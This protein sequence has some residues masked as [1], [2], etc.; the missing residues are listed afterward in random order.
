LVF[1]DHDD[2]MLPHCIESL[3]RSFHLWPDV[4]AAHSDHQLL[5]VRDGSLIR[6]HHDQS[7][8]FQ[9]MKSIPTLA[10]QGNTRLYG[11]E[12]YT[13]LL[14]GNLLQQ[15]WIVDRTALQSVGGYDEKIRYCEDWDLYL[16]ITRRFQVVLSDD[17]LSIH[18]IE[19]SNLHLAE[20]VKQN[21]MYH[22][23]LSKQYRSAED[24]LSRS[25]KR[26]I[27]RKMASFGKMDGDWL[28]QHGKTRKAWLS[29]LESARWDPTDHVVLARLILWIP[30]CFKPDQVST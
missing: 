26:M 4:A 21:P 5:D 16:R 19:G 7:P 27:H 14:R 11:R 10:A 1:L 30:M 9:R 15:P 24:S 13:A 25:E 3:E 20:S 8:A 18:R 12:L 17:V 28:Y 29:Y 23:V 2:L 6:N 22:R